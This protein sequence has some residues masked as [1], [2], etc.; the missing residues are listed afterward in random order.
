MLR[1]VPRYRGMPRAG[2]RGAG[3]RLVRPR[4]RLAGGLNL[5]LCVVPR[6]RS[7]SRLRTGT[8]RGRGRDGNVGQLLNGAGQH[9]RISREDTAQPSRC[10][11]HRR[12]QPGPGPNW[13]P[14][15]PGPSAPHWP[16]DSGGDAGRRDSLAEGSPHCR[17]SG[18]LTGFRRPGQGGEHPSQ[19][20]H[21]ARRAG[22][23]GAPSDKHVQQRLVR[24]AAGPAGEGK[25]RHLT[26]QSVW[27]FQ[28]VTPAR[29]ASSASRRR[30]RCAVTRTAPG[31]LP[32]IRATS[33]ASSPAT[34]RSMMISA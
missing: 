24:L 34:T 12:G 4:V 7:A 9:A 32:T 25:P 18:Q 21:L 22:G 16:S 20:M 31:V 26:L 1:L 19:V 5:A 33:A 13:S 10:R 15:P 11:D 14:G 29:S 30:A 3:R 17:L 8:G 27:L 2:R 28:C 23:E 6:A